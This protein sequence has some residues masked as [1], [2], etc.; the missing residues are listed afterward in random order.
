MDGGIYAVPTISFFKTQFW[1]IDDQYVQKYD[2]IWTVLVV[3]H[4]LILSSVKDERRQK[5]IHFIRYR[6]IEVAGAVYSIIMMA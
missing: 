1:L 4:R 2:V 3:L 6:C 5:A